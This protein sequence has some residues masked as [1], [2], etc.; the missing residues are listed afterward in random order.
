M[1]RLPVSP[2]TYNNLDASGTRA[3]V[4]E[5]STFVPR[6]GPTVRAPRRDAQV[7][8]SVTSIA[9][10]SASLPVVGAW[11]PR[12]RRWF[13]LGV[14]SCAVAWIVALWWMR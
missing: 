6:R 14:A 11:D 3:H 5:A 9:P 4:E 13:W 1:S 8:T 7:E 2:G 10:A 12:E